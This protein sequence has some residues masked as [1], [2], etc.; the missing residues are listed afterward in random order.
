M[1]VFLS[2]PRGLRRRFAARA[3]RTSGQGCERAPLGDREHRRRRLGLDRSEHGAK[4]ENA[5]RAIL[6]FLSITVKR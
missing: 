3:A 6:V 5:E 2:P 4:I 1:V